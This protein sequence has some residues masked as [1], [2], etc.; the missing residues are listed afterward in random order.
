M[1]TKIS[2][3]KK[4]LI[5]SVALIAALGV[6]AGSTFAW[7][8]SNSTVTVSGF[9]SNVVSGSD[10]L[11]MAVTAY[12]SDDT[13][14]AYNALTYSSTVTNEQIKKAILGGSATAASP[15][16]LAALTAKN[17]QT[18]E[19]TPDI[20]DG[21][22]FET[23]AGNQVTD[24][25]STT[26]TEGSYVSFKVVFRNR[27]VVSENTARY[28]A[29]SSDSTIDRSDNG[30]SIPLPTNQ[31]TTI[32]G[33]ITASGATYYGSELKTAGAAADRR[34]TAYAADAVRVS[35][36]TS[37]EAGNSGK[38]WSPYERY[39]TGG[40]TDDPSQTAQTNAR[41]YYLNNLANDYR[42]DT[43]GTASEVT[44]KAYTSSVITAA[45]A[46]DDVKR[47]SKNLEAF[48]SDDTYTYTSVVV[49]IWIE[50]TDGDCFDAILQDDFK[51]TLKFSVEMVNAVI[52]I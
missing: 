2:S 14:E 3:T 49:N 24:P 20:Y 7:F 44:Q 18:G 11:T 30:K 6:A 13:Q 46:S 48:N 29:L 8:A 23:E 45:N 28:I 22:A 37:T 40:N 32:D 34:L 16:Y 27:N 35:F 19:A 51:L 25:N 43:L 42:N 12:D 26:L 15:I 10:S 4:I 31:Y 36:V 9:E 39:A 5:S 1:K 33:N 21:T 38:V 50:G 17:T 52:P 47:I 41:G